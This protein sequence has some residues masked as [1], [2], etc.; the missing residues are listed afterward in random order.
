MK[1]LRANTFRRQQ[2]G[3]RLPSGV[4]CPASIRF[5][6]WRQLALQGPSSGLGS[7]PGSVDAVIGCVHSQ[8][9][10]RSGSLCDRCGLAS[11]L[12]GL[13]PIAG[14]REFQNHGVMDHSIHR[15]GRRHRIFEDLVPLAKHQ[16]AR[17][18]D[19][20]SRVRCE[21][22][23]LP[24]S[25]SRSAQSRQHARIRGA[26]DCCRHEDHT[27]RRPSHKPDMSTM[28]ERVHFY[29]GLIISQVIVVK[30]VARGSLV[31]ISCRAWD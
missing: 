16:I 4:P 7:R 23:S 15:R 21:C 10:F 28:G 18:H 26:N 5:E 31:K 17:D 30:S 27:R 13:G 12:G 6:G 8:T 1:S 14:D 24:R 3:R 11:R 25:R 20:A 9:R 22:R 19:R 29:C 2:G